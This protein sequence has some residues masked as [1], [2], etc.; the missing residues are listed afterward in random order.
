MMK[1]AKSIKHVRGREGESGPNDTGHRYKKFDRY[2]NQEKSVASY[3]MSEALSTLLR[4][5]SNAFSV[6]TSQDYEMRGHDVM[7]YIDKVGGYL[8]R[9]TANLEN[10]Y[11]EQFRFVC[12]M[13]MLRRAE[14]LPSDPKIW[15]PP[16]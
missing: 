11:W 4:Y 13:Q 10:E 3:P 9:P 12:Q 16:E 6:V 15:T 2:E 7:H 14:N 1:K 8:P 5:H